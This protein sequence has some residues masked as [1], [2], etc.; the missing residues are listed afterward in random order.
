MNG[1]RVV[2]QFFAYI[3]E[4]MF[5][6]MKMYDPEQW[7]PHY[8]FLIMLAMYLIAHYVGKSRKFREMSR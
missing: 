3:G 2:S 5:E 4:P 7:N 8:S 1:E 6:W